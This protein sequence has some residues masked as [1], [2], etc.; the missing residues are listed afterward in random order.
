MSSRIKINVPVIR[1]D[2]FKRTVA[3]MEMKTDMNA[4]RRL[5]R[6]GRHDE[7][8]QEKFAEIPGGEV[9]LFARMGQLPGQ[10]GFRLRGMVEPTTGIAVIAVKSAVGKTAG[11]LTCAELDMD[12]IKRELVWVDSCDGGKNIIVPPAAGSKSE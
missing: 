5:L 4:L 6:A 3:K 7:I 1:I 8:G 2:S 10:P 11:A 12:W 9:W